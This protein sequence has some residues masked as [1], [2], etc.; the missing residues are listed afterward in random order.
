MFRREIMKISELID[1]IRKRD[2]VLPEFQ[3]EFVWSKDQA[4]QLM[5]SLVKGY[6][7]GSLLFWKTDKPP[8]LKNIAKL[9]DKFGILQ[10][11]LDGQQRLTTLYMLITGEIPPYYKNVDIHTDPRELYYN[12]D[13][14]DFQYYLPSK[15]RGNPLWWRTV[16]CFTKKDKINIFEIAKKIAKDEQ[17]AFDLAQ[18]YSDNLNKLVLIVNIDFPEQLVPYYAKLF[19]AIDIFDRVNR[20]GTKL[21]DAE[22]ALTH[23]TGKWSDARRLMK[24]KIEELANRNFQFDLTFMIRCLTGVVTKR[25][26]F[27][28]IHDRTREE[29]EE[30]WNNLKKILDYIGVILP[31]QAFV[32]SA[33]DLNTTNILVPLVVYL[34]INKGKFPNERSLKKA[35]HWL[36]AAHTWARYTAQTDQRLEHDISLIMREEKPWDE[37]CNQIIDQRGRI[38]V[39]A[40]D[41][42]GRGV[43]HPL[44]RMTLI[45]A[46]A[47]GALDWFNGVALGSKANDKAYCIHNH[48]IFPV[49]LLYKSAYDPDNH[50][51]KKIINEIANRAF[52]T[53]E[54]NLSISNKPPEEYLPEIEER[55]PGALVKQFVP[56]DPSLWK[57]NRFPDFLEKRRALITCKLNEFMKSLVAKPEVSSERPIIDIIALGESATL[58]FKSTLQWDVVRNCIN[59]DL[60]HSVI[61]TIAAFLNSNGGILIIGVEDDGKVKGLEKDLK[62]LRN[63]KDRF[64]QLLNTLMSDYIGPEYSSFIRIRFENIDGNKICVVKA[65][66]A[67]EPAFLKGARGKEFHIRVGNTT[68]MLDPE[69]TVRYIQMNWE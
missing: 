56:M 58:E 27:H 22:L 36:Y 30:G 15:M 39:K 13:S 48:H 21:T 52:L 23:V 50:L 12:L 65:D 69:E 7:V 16:D 2:L 47:H 8:E 24:N 60:R 61:K 49:S 53:A 6:P 3:R 43:L 51:H 9:P 20:Q 31:G 46:K 44:H 18:R 41:L 57:L 1:S 66:K 29:L 10:V 32:H 26:L 64:E 25:A 63:S 45:L 33:Y 11:I 54:S 38:E 59:K 62:T 28:T 67:Q 68:H 19:D 4:K 17:G 40:N 14:G 55:F 42:E 5:V 34:S 35:I 37:L